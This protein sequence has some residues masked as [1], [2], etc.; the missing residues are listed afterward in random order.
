MKNNIYFSLKKILQSER[1]ESLSPSNPPYTTDYRIEGLKRGPQMVPHYAEE[2][3][4]C[5]SKFFL[6]GWKV[7]PKM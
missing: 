3:P 5:E 6:S 2:L 7:I 4:D 1:L